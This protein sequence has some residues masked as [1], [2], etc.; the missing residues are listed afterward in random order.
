[1]TMENCGLSLPSMAWKK[2]LSCQYRYHFSS[3]ACGSKTLL[4]CPLPMKSL[5]LEYLQF[6]FELLDAQQGLHA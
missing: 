6:L 4:N 2:S 1:M 3:A 5:L